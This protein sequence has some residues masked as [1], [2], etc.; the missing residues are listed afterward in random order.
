MQQEHFEANK[1]M[2]DE[3]VPI[4]VASEMYDHDAFMAGQ[5]SLI[6]VELAEMGPVEGKSLVHLQCH[7]GHDTLSW[8]RLGATVTGLDFSGPAVEQATRLAQ[9]IGLD[10]ARFVESDVYQQ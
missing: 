8:G 10:D 4:H 3:R 5:N 6:P 2:W 1:A 7:F 9:A